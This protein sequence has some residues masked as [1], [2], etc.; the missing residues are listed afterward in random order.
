MVVHD[1]STAKLLESEHT[2]TLTGAPEYLAP[3]QVKGGGH[4][5]AADLWALGVLLYESHAGRCP[6]GAVGEAGGELRVYAQITEH[7]TG[8]LR[9]PAHVDHAT[10]ALLDGC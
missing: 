6:F 7:K 2:L 8:E 4:G 10:H 9:C 1:Y 5:L 3:E